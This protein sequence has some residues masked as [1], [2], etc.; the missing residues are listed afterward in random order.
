MRRGKGIPPRMLVTSHRATGSIRNRDEVRFADEFCAWAQSI[1]MPRMHGAR[2]NDGISKIVQYKVSTSENEN[3]ARASLR[4]APRDEKKHRA[5]GQSGSKNGGEG[6]TYCFRGR[7]EVSGP[8]GR[9]KVSE[10]HRRRGEDE[11]FKKWHFWCAGNSFANGGKVPR[12]LDSFSIVKINKLWAAGVCKNTTHTLRTTKAFK[13][14]IRMK[15]DRILGCVGKYGF[16]GVRER[17]RGR[18]KS[19]KTRAGARK[20]TDNYDITGDRQNLKKYRISGKFSPN[21]IVTWVTRVTR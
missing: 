2:K 3:F 10:R 9:R 8:G 17:I 15:L 6:R 5:E 12:S 7:D 14:N 1:W 11:V 21:I 20:F 18:Q 13:S 16:P 4:N 19:G